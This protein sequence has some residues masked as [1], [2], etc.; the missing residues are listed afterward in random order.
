MTDI[1][2]TDTT[3][4]S[5]DLLRAMQGA[6]ELAD[7]AVSERTK[8]L[9]ADEFARFSK[10]ASK[11]GVPSLPATAAVVCTYIW[12]M[13]DDGRSYSSA[14]LAK[15]AIKQTHERHRIALDLDTPDIR[16]LMRGFRR[17]LATQGRK[18]N[19]AAPFTV[20]MWCR[21][22]EGAGASLR[23]RR[24]VA[25]IGFGLAHALRGPSELLHLDMTRC[26]SP[27]ALGSVTVNAVGASV[28]L[29]KTKTSQF[30]GE[31]IAIENSPAVEALRVWIEAAGIA[32][33]TPT[34]RSFR[35]GVLTDGRMSDRSF[36]YMIQSRAAQALEF[37]GYS[38]TDAAA[39]S[40]EYSTH[41][42]RRGALTSLGDNGASISDIMK[43]SRHASGSVKIAMDYVRTDNGGS[44][45]MAH[46]LRGTL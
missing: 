14:M 46:L 38:S 4:L 15:S 20:E 42:L 22:A 33:G 2:T 44:S 29:A 27:D 11:E 35:N 25:M 45:A 23:A 18:I 30:D 37:E 24:D 9:Y 28:T 3:Q 8:K 34:W 1:I 43:L 13:F 5:P 12:T 39:M 41:S 19:K 31:F 17:R 10:W 21:L 40:L 6:A 16:N 32:P 36:Q 7:D 26:G